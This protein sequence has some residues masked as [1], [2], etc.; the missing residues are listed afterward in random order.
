M[1][2]KIII[3]CVCKKIII[4][5]LIN[6]ENVHTNGNYLNVSSDLNVRTVCSVSSLSSTFVRNILFRL[7]PVMGVYTWRVCCRSL[8]VVQR[9]LSIN[10]RH[11]GMMFINHALNTCTQTRQLFSFLYGSCLQCT[12]DIAPRNPVLRDMYVNNEWYCPR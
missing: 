12:A 10:S 5:L 6:V 8:H 9:N 1:L 4:K 11:R 3:V 7:G 2:I